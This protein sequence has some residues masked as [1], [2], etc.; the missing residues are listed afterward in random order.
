MSAAQV[1][2]D[3]LIVVVLDKSGSMG[4]CRDEVTSGFNHFIE[5]QKKVP[6]NAS[7]SIVMFDTVY[8]TPVV[9]I[10]LERINVLD[11]TN[12]TP[13]GNT[14]LLDAVGRA[15]RDADVSAGDRQVVFVIVTDG[16]E[17][18]SHE[19]TRTRIKELITERQGKGWDFIFLGA[20]QDAF[21][22]AQGMGVPTANVANYSSTVRGQTMSAFTSATV[23][24]M[25]KRMTG[26]VDPNWKYGS[27]LDNPDAADADKTA[28]TK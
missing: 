1:A 20:N 6:G 3:T 11:K 19:F 24:T 12:Y 25:S 26:K 23:G 17:N 9:N 22:E 28:L 10:P 16:Q 15:I 2:K 14:A 27:G 18:S 5:E 13:Y 7:V 8:T 21:S 4:S